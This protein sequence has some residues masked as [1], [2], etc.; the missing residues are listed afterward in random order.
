MKRK[1][2]LYLE[3]EEHDVVIQSLLTWKNKLTEEGRYTDAIDDVL[4]KVINA[5]IK[6][7]KVK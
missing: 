3:S 7:V 4:L 1:Y 5:P 6:K 2:H